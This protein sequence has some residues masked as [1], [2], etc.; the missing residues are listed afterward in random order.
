MKAAAYGV[1]CVK[2]A[3]KTNSPHVTLS[4]RQAITEPSCD[5]SVE[6]IDPS[7][8]E[9]ESRRNSRTRAR[10]QPGLFY[11]SV[12]GSVRPAMVGFF[13]PGPDR[14]ALASGSFVLTPN[15]S[16]GNLLDAFLSS[17]YAAR[18]GL[19]VG[20]LIEK[21]FGIIPSDGAA[22]G[23]LHGYVISVGDAA[24]QAL[25]LIGEGIRYSVEAGRR[26]GEAI[27]AAL[28]DPSGAE[29]SLQSYQSWWDDKYRARF[30]LAQRANEKMGRFSDRRWHQAI[31]L[32][33][34][35]SGDEMAALLRMDFGRWLALKLVMRGGLRAAGFSLAANRGKPRTEFAEGTKGHSGLG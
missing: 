24:G 32:L 34:G 6:V 8:L 33:N 35:L 10:N 4:M 11:L 2:K 29:A 18:L 21:H 27:A 17:A 3:S 19:R 13:R 26:A 5:R 31:G 25:P 7:G 15:L 20:A 1:P 9:L 14:S 23:F 12:P 28:R 30:T 16:A 22:P